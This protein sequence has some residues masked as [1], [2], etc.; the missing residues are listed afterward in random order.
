MCFLYILPRL[1]KKTFLNVFYSVMLE[2]VLALAVSG[3][4]SVLPQLFP[5]CSRVIP[6]G[7]CCLALVLSDHAVRR[8]FIDS[9]RRSVTDRLEVSGMVPGRGKSAKEMYDNSKTASKPGR[10]ELGKSEKK[11]QKS[12]TNSDLRLFYFVHFVYKLL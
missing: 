12:E 4:G 5:V 3:A 10:F 6:G 9:R 8:G 11:S 7:L 2:F 1:H